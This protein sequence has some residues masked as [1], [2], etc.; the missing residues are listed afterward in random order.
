MAPIVEMQAKI[1]ES[2]RPIRE[3]NER[4]AHRLQPITDM[5]WRLAAMTPAVVLPENFYKKS[6]LVSEHMLEVQRQLQAFVA[7]VFSDLSKH[8]KGLPE[9]T[10]NALTV[11]G[12]N[13]WY[14]DLEMPMSALWDLESLLSENVDEAQTSLVEYFRGRVADIAGT[15]KTAFPRRARIIE[16]AFAAHARGEYE[17]CIPVFLAQADGICQDLI[18]FPLFTKR[19]KKPAPAAFVEAIA[20]DTF[21]SAMMHPLTCALPVSFTAGERGANFDGLNRHQVLH[22][23]SVDYGTEINSLKAI[24]LL[25]YVFQVLRKDD[26]K[27]ERD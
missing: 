23:E 2:L 10:R 9:R 17:L 26:D 15:L 20:A 19:G 12:N 11:L 13:G 4:I 16:K 18:E 27:G 25:N 21:R 14:L 1:A 22:G 8:L 7:P 3:L 24:S 5:Q 6:L